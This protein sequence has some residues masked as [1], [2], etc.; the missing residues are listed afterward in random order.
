MRGI[1]PILSKNDLDS[2]FF[3]LRLALFLDSRSFAVFFAVNFAH[4]AHIM[5]DGHYLY[6]RLYYTERREHILGYPERG[7]FD[8]G[9]GDGTSIF[10]KCITGNTN[11]FYTLERFVPFIRMSG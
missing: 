2:S 11:G 5:I 4:N 3:G 9:D 8:R 6:N 10:Y 1:N 7:A